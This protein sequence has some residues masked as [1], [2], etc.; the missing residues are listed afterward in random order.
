MSFINKF[1]LNLIFLNYKK[2]KYKIDQTIEIN[3]NVYQQFMQAI[4]D[5]N[6]DYVR[7]YAEHLYKHPR[8][9]IEQNPYYCLP[10]ETCAFYGRLDI[11]ELLLQY[12]QYDPSEYNN[13]A[14]RSAVVKGHP[15]VFDRLIKDSRVYN[16]IQIWR[17]NSVSKANELIASGSFHGQIEMVDRL[18]EL[19]FVDPSADNNRAIQYSIK[20]GRKPK[21]TNMLFRDIRVYSTYVPS[22]DRIVKISMVRDRVSEVC[23]A[24][25]D[26]G[27]PTLVTLK[28]IDALV[29]NNIPMYQKWN[30]VVTMKHFKSNEDV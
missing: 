5:D 11:L 13:I 15:N 25:Q 24:L 29:P 17:R 8:T 19:P 10:I 18:L 3:E 14:M 28:I 21:I 6:I 22:K 16:T 9:L 20:F 2:K 7:Q 27:L 12:N 4:K 30:L 1:Y 23:F 26:L